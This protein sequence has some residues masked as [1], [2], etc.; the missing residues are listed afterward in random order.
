MLERHVPGSAVSSVRLALTVAAAYFIADTLMNKI[1]LGDGWEI[2]WPLNG[3][4]IA[5]LI[6]RP[7]SS[8]PLLLAAVELGTGVGRIHRRQLALSTLV[9]RAF[10]ALEVSLS[11]AL[12]PPFVS[13]ATW[14]PK[15]GLYPRFAAAVAGGSHRLGRAGCRLPPLD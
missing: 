12:L 1:A 7:R 5:L 11:A 6:M 14:L 9:E 13:L 10:S 15:P 8:W 3:I 2:F 4:T